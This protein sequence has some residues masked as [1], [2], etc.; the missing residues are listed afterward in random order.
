MTATLPEP[1]GWTIERAE[2]LLAS[3][4]GVLSARVVARPGGEIDEIH[5]LTTTEVEPKQTVRNVESALLARFDLEVDHRKISVARTDEAAAVEDE[6][7]EEEEAEPTVSALMLHRTGPASDEDGPRMLFTGHS[8]ASER[9]QRVRTSVSL[10][11]R[12]RSYEGEAVGADLPRARAE[13]LAR[14]TLEAVMSAAR[15]GGDP[16]TAS[17][18]LSLTLDG[19]KSTEAF[20]RAYVL[21]G[22]H[23]QD[24]RRTIALTGAAPVE[25]DTDRSV[26]L[27]TLQATDRWIRGR[28]G[29]GR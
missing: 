23:A 27:A 8:V 4:A 5:L 15:E 26:I 17:D 11:W 12:G 28:I 14:A 21:V 19:V 13:G 25:Q 24:G 2:R 1:A 22:V 9:D 3:L 10:E 20:E 18:A 7:P 16:E 6:D 29:K